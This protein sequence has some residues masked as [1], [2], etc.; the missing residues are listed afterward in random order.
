MNYLGD[1][2]CVFFFLEIFQL[3][4]LFFPRIN[5]LGYLI[6]K[7]GEQKYLLC[8]I[9]WQDVKK[10]QFTQ[11]RH[12]QTKNMALSK[13]AWWTMESIETTYRSMDD[14]GNYV[15]KSQL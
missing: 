15:T 4:N 1:F 3:P 2:L 6:R 5:V 7:A 13:P 8:H 11:V 14:L 12:Q 10:W 9:S